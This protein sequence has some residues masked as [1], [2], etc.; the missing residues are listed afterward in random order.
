[1]SNVE[2]VGG[3][4]L[5]EPPCTNAPRNTKCKSGFGETLLRAGQTDI[6]KN[7]AAAFLDRNFIGHDLAGPS[8]HHGTHGSVSLCD[9]GYG[10]YPG[11]GTTVD[12]VPQPMGMLFERK[13][14]SPT[15]E[16]L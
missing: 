1:V 11:C 3:A 9:S 2:Y 12:V 6:G 8:K 14:D 16:S 7:V 4:S 13:A 5:G 10:G 15:S